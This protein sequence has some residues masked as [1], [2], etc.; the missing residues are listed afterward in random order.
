MYTIDDIRKIEEFCSKTFSG[1]KLSEV[2]KALIKSL[3][4][5]NTEAICHWT[6]ELICSGHYI[7]LWDIIILYSSRNIHCGNIKLPLYLELRFNLFKKIIN[8]GYL[9]SEIKLRNN[10]TIR[11]LFLEVMFVMSHANK[12]HEF[13]RTKISKTEYQLDYLRGRFKADNLTYVNQIFKTE[14]P[15]DMFIAVNELIYHLSKTKDIMSVCYWI[16]WILNFDLHCKKNK[17]IAASRDYVENEKNQ[18]DYVW[19]IWDSIKLIIRPKDKLYHNIF[20]SLVTLFTIKYTTSTKR[21]RVYIIY[22]A[23][24]LAIDK[25]DTATQIIKDKK[26]IDVYVKT[27]EKMFKHLKKNEVLKKG[28]ME[29]SGEYNE[30]YLENSLKKLEYMNNLNT[31]K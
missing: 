22:W 6:C 24:Y 13:K 9:G 8:N 25:V 3:I 7:V 21:K 17:I 23:V 1:Y 18:K 12:R 26:T 31:Y 19:L 30:G 10:A 2:K 20:D 4:D 29:Y 5:N 16:E 14:D 11:Q 28:K 15:K 27:G